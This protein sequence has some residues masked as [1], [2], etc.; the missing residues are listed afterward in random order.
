MIAEFFIE[1]P[2]LANVIA[3]LM[4]LLG[5]VSLL[6][7]PV[8]QYPSMTPPTIQ[9]T[10][11]FPGASAVIV[12][13]QVGRAIEQQVNGVEGM[14][15]MQS[16][17]SDDGR[18]SLTVSFAV[19]TDTD[20]AQIAVQNRV[21]IAIPTLPASVQQ[22][23]VVTK[24]KSTAILQIVTLTSTDA[25]QDALFLSNFAGL[26]LRDN[27]AR[28]PGVADV[29]VFGIGQYSMRV[30]LDAAQMSQ[31]GLNPSTVVSVIDQQNQ[32]V[33]AGQTGMPPAPAGQ[34]QELT[35]NVDSPLTSA[36]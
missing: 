30:W 14:I 9:V 29:S 27:L 18:Y 21:A 31:R 26:R 25:R 22:Q 17:A 24:K 12:Q 6:Q 3:I 34:Q 8:A 7:L 36:R 11:S 5:G 10:T 13:Q 2:I 23:G 19:G 15:Y 32:T 16:N 28:V 4:L 1:R 35:I 33:T 20:Q